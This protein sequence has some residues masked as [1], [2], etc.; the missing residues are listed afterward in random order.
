[1]THVRQKRR[2]RRRRRRSRRRRRTKKNVA[3]VGRTAPIR[4]QCYTNRP[5][6]RD[7]NTLASSIDSQPASPV[8]HHGFTVSSLGCSCREGADI[9]MRGYMCVFFCSCCFS[10]FM[11]L[12]LQNGVVHRD[13]KLENVL[14][15]ENCNIKVRKR[16]TFLLGVA[17]SDL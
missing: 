5:P 1:M 3:D 2:R 14:L 8:N 6:E 11:C 10:C 15:D 7:S 17:L 4:Q 13:L 12:F 9:W 16:S